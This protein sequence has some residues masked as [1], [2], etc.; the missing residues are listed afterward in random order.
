MRHV[1]LLLVL[2]T[3]CGQEGWRYGDVRRKILREE[4]YTHHDLA[5]KLTSA[6]REGPTTGDTHLR[7]DSFV[8]DG[9]PRKVVFAHPP[10]RLIFPVRV[11]E[12]QRLVTGAA[13]HPG[14]WDKEGDGVRFMVKVRE[15]GGNEQLLGSVYVDPKHRGRDRRWHDL[16]FDLSAHEGDV[17]GIVLETT[18]GSSGDG[19]YDWGGWVEPLIVSPEQPP[20]PPSIVLIT[21]GSLRADYL[22][23]YGA[24]QASTPGID[25]LAA[26]GYLF[27]QAYATSDDQVRALTGLLASRIAPEL[28]AELLPGVGPETLAE[29]GTASGY[30]TAALIGS[31]ML[32]QRLGNLARGCHIVETPEED[33]WDAKELTGKV[34]QWMTGMVGKKF[35]IW[36]HYAD[37][38]FEIP[39]GTRADEARQLYAERVS[40]VDSELQ[41]L[42]QALVAAG[43][44]SNTV[45]VLGSDRGRLLGE[46]DMIGGARGLYTPVVRV[47]LILRYP[48]MWRGGRQLN[49]L[50]QSVD[51]PATVADLA[52]LTLRIADG[53]SL[54]GLL[55]DLATMV[56]DEV[57]AASEDERMAMSSQWLYLERRRKRDGLR[58]GE[59]LYDLLADPVQTTNVMAEHPEIAHQ[60]SQSVEELSW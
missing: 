31:R 57:R 32:A 3:A 44:E 14:S 37:L 53:R 42:L 15:P 4:L 46:R 10:L 55:S 49:C 18:F 52:D 34:I 24:T 25:L 33:D 23:C 39:S 30:R 2:A 7:V 59:E 45:V 12:G 13:M 48:D 19:S 29:A 21:V 60:M 16:A 54:V 11:L 5:R 43:L 27:Q 41:R 6:L 36:A 51:L 9:E 56:R 17:V 8:I 22:G 58:P 35:L 47:P 1:L 38:E 50:V 26:G 28:G 20:P 40:A